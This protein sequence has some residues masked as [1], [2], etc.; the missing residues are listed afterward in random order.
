MTEVILTYH[1]TPS[2]SPPST[3]VLF[4]VFFCCCYEFGNSS[5]H[6]KVDFTFNGFDLLGALIIQPKSK[7]EEMFKSYR[8]GPLLISL[9]NKYIYLLLKNR[10]FWQVKTSLLTRTKHNMNDMLQRR[11]EEMV[12]YKGNASN[13]KGN[14]AIVFF[15]VI[16]DFWCSSTI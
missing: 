7:S 8:T 11:A 9:A 6:A 10:W 1:V 5:S 2:D 3:F 4:D 14:I 16:T 12:S 13:L 15:F